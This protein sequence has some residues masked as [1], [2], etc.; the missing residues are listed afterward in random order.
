MS[1]KS[2][3]TGTGAIAF[4]FER[5]TELSY[6]RRTIFVSQIAVSFN[7]APNAAGR[8]MIYYEDSEGKDL[9]YDENAR[10]KQVIL[11]SPNSPVPIIDGAKITIEYENPSSR[12]VTARVLWQL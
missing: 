5:N 2:R 8:L 10:N 3:F 4:E 11:F 12:E 6:N 7:T 1:Q 9:I